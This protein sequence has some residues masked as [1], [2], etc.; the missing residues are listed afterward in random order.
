MID[1]ETEWALL[2]EEM[3]SKRNQQIVGPN[4]GATVNPLLLGMLAFLLVFPWLAQLLP[5]QL[6]DYIALLFR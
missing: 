4:P 5:Q 3:E 6:R 2:R 1:I